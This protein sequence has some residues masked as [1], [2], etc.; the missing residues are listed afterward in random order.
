MVIAKKAQD[1]SSP[2]SP[3]MQ[4]IQTSSNEMARVLLLLMLFLRQF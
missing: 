4:K 1:P 2:Y 3:M